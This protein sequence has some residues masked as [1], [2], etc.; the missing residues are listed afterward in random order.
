MLPTQVLGRFGVLAH[1][2]GCGAVLPAAGVGAALGLPWMRTD[3]LLS[4]LAVNCVAVS[5]ELG[6]LTRERARCARFGQG[7]RTSALEI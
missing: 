1:I 7:H 6:S 3:W 5:A 4:A 2:Y